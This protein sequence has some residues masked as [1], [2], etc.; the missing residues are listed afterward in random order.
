V[1]YIDGEH[2]V[3]VAVEEDQIVELIAKDLKVGLYCLQILIDNK[4]FSTKI[5]IIK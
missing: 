4:S 2:A 3:E 1:L 5:S